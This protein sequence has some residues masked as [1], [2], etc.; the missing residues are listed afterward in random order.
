MAQNTAFIIAGAGLAGAKAAETLRAEGFDGP[1]VLLGDEH[2]RPYE[3]PPLSKGYLL[4]T[5]EKE[6]V[7]VHPPQWYAEHDVD[8]R[9]GNAVTAL[10]PAGHEVTLADGSTLGYAKLLLATGSTPR[11]LPVPGADLDGVHTLRRL[12]DS[13]RLKEVFRSASR[14]V[15]VG[16]GWIGLETTA[17]ARAAGAEVTVL[18][19]APLPLLGVLGPEVAQIFADLHTGHG[20]ALRCGA[21]VTE[22][23]GTDGAV[24]GVRLADGTR[25]AADAVIVGIGITPNSEPAAAAG[26]KVD[27]GVVVDERLCSSHPDIYAAGD[28]A[29]AYHPLLG[30]HLRVEHWANA[31]HQ[32]RTAAQ[33]MLGRE[34]RY[35]RLPYFFTDQYDLGMEYT[36]Y[37]GPEGY[38]RVVFRGDTGAREFIAFWLSGG[39]VLAGMNVNVWDVTDPIRALVASGRAVDPERL[40]DTDVSLDALVP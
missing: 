37:V 26:L 13:D 9:L 25:I 33:A 32:P 15:V 38:D 4:G 24:D 40:A 36:G 17:A 2:E 22:I 14:V 29:S 5:S 23:T 39:R 30:R 28:V 7:Y 34:V 1:V 16:G 6:K 27:N 21:Q 31:L 12:A 19:S 8:L 20:V 3:R 35:D 10:D 11:P 18:E